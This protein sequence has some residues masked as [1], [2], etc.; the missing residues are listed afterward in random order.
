MRVRLNF[1][2]LALYI[3]SYADIAYA[4]ASAS[5]DEIRDG[6]GELLDGIL[7]VVIQAEPAHRQFPGA[8]YIGAEITPSSGASALYV[9]WQPGQDPLGSWA[10]FNGGLIPP[11][12]AFAGG[13]PSTPTRYVLYQ[14][15][16]LCDHI[17][18]LLPGWGPGG[19]AVA[20]G[21]GYGFLYEQDT[22][23]ITGI[24]ARQQSARTGAENALSTDHIALA[25][26][27]RNGFAAATYWAPI[28]TIQCAP[29]GRGR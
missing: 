27:Q 8:H 13:L 19:F 6:R 29:V 3:A 17:S 26:I 23:A 4:S 2:F 7:S 5:Y 21:A 15:I 20:L 11:A 10:Q 14:G 12:A 18:R 24:R 9:Y 25:Y 28:W 16:A 22:T 1:M